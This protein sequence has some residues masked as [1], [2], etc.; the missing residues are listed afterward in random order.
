MKNLYAILFVFVLLGCKPGKPAGI[1][2]ESKMENILVDYHLAQGM[3]ENSDMGLEQ[4]RYEYIQTVFNKHGITEAAFDSSMVYY[5]INAEVLAQIYNK[6]AKRIEAQTALLGEGG[7]TTQNKYAH[8]S[9]QGDTANIWTESTYHTLNKEPLT[10]MFRFNI[11]A[12]STFKTGDSFLWRFNSSF[13][14]ETMSNEAIAIFLLRYDNDSVVSRN[15]IIRS[16]GWTEMRL[17]SN[18]VDTL[19]VKSVSG[20]IY[21]PLPPKKEKKFAVLLLD[22]MALIRFHRDIVSAKKDTATIE[23]PEKPDTLIHT[24]DE[25]AKTPARQAPADLRDH[26]NQQKRINVQ[27]VKPAKT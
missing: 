5:S 21:M 24:E 20:Y 19:D 8:L 26:R 9:A 17:P 15:E 11:E 6:V 4:K 10:H 23:T 16:D 14:A 12:D 18:N 27:K 2:S 22:E 13:K 7:H 25:Q 3:A 1:L